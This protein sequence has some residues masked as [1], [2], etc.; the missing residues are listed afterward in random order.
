MACAWVLGCV[1]STYFMVVDIHAWLDPENE[2]EEDARK[3]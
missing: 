3:I 1:T 2:E